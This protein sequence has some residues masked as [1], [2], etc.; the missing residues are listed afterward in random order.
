MGLRCY[1]L[2]PLM[3]AASRTSASVQPARNQHDDQIVCPQPRD[4]MCATGRTLMADH[5]ADFLDRPSLV[6]PNVAPPGG[7]PELLKDVFAGGLAGML[8]GIV[9]IGFGSRVVMR[10]LALLNPNSR[11]LLTDNDNVIGE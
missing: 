5:A 8:A 3:I 7:L 9:F 4:M 1:R 11:G 10:A 6:T 2:S